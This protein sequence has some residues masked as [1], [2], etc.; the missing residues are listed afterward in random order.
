ML[1]IR[2]TAILVSLTMPAK[3]YRDILIPQ[4]ADVLHQ[5]VDMSAE[6]DSRFRPFGLHD[7]GHICIM[8][9]H[10]QTDPAEFLW[11]EPDL[12]RAIFCLRNRR[13]QLRRDMRGKRWCP[14]TCR[15]TVGQIGHLWER[16]ISNHKIVRHQRPW[17]SLA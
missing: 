9:L 8:A 4:G 7:H 1:E 14:R 10:D 3:I 2:T 5:L 16:P 13:G 15:D 6:Q 12:R 11:V 17:N